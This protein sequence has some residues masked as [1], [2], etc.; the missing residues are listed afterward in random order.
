[1]RSEQGAAAEEALAVRTRTGLGR[2]L[3]ALYGVFTIGAVSRSLVQILTRFDS[4]PLAFVLSAVAA[5]FYIVATVSLARGSTASRS[6]ATA[7][8]VIEFVGVV[9]VGTLS[10]V[11]P[12]LFPEPTVWSHFGQGYLYFPVVLPLLGLWW[13]RQTARAATG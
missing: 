5:V 1:M 12:E 10:Y 6:V 7:S 2:V 11:R 4:A 13:L 8:C 3:I 9:A